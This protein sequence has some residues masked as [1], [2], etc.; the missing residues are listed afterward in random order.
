MELRE[1]MVFNRV[2]LYKNIIEHCS[3]TIRA[4][5]YNNSEY[6]LLNMMSV[7]IIRS[8]NIDNGV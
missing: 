8:L 5:V 4:Y 6:D 3:D 2:E 7:H 1:K